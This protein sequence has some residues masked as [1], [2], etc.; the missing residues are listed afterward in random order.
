VNESL[1]MDEALAARPEHLPVGPIGRQG[2]GLWGVATLIATEAAL[3]GYL[4]FA[5][6]YTGAT[7]PAGWVLDPYPKL[8][9]ALP[10]TVL[11]LSS[12]VAA[13]WG[14]SGVKRGR[15][16]QALA[17]FVLTI[18]M[19]AA[20]L[21]LEWMEWRSRP[22]MFGSSSYSSL[23]FVTSGMHILHVIVGLI[24]LA[25]LCAWTAL[26]YFSPRRRL[27]VA[28]GILYWHFVNGVSVLVFVTFYVTPYLGFGR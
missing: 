14:E 28:A 3:F 5:Y 13:A 12:S 15:R 19:G 26:R 21:I 9:I 11:L 7:A 17:G 2:V 18:L 23:Y 25:A 16:G 27:V 4:F 20:F 8:S 6:F 10:S 1:L 24:V 22:F